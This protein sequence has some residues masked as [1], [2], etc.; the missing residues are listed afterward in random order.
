VQLIFPI[1]E[2]TVVPPPP[3][4]ASTAPL[5]PLRILFVD[6]AHAVG[7]LGENG[8]GTKEHFHIEND[9]CQTT[10]TLSKALGGSGGVI[11]GKTDWIEN[12]DRNSRVMAGASPPPLPMAAASACALEI[13]HK[14]PELRQ[15]LRQKVARVRAGFC[16]LGWEVEDSPVPIICLA[17]REGVDLLKI[18]NGLFEQGIAVEY[19]HSYPSSPP[20]GALRIAIFATHSSE[21]IERLLKVTAALI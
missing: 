13:A 4:P 12:I 3:S 21:Q 16:R 6:D 17:A 15:Q 8:R 19:V 20:G 14:S 7:V 5:D 10:G 9:R 11:W 18:R 1:R 2:V